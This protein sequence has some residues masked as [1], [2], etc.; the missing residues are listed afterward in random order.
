MSSDPLDTLDAILA[1]L[2]T[3]NGLAETVAEEELRNRLT[4]AVTGL[5]SA[6]LTARGEVQHMQEQ[7]EH[8]L[9]QTRQYGGELRPGGEV[10]PRGTQPPRMKWGC[11]QFDDTEGLFCTACYDKRN[12]RI[13][14]MRYNSANLVCPNCR[15]LFPVR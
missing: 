3:M 12:R 14:T 11:Y 10:R 5:R 13:R 8:T 9:S 15:A 2:H 4:A 6:V 1:G 7:F